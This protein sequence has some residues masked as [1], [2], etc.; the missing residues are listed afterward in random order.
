MNKNHQNSQHLESKKNNQ[1]ST[2]LSH[3]YHAGPNSNPDISRATK[4]SPPTVT[5]LIQEL[6]DDNL[7]MDMGMGTSI[8][9]RRPNLY[10]ILPDIRYVIG[11]DIDCRMVNIGLFNLATR[12]KADVITYFGN[13]KDR[14]QMF[15]ELFER[16]DE[17]LAA[18]HVDR[19]K[20]LG[21]GVSIPGL[22]NASTGETYE[23]I[24]ING[25]KLSSMF[26]ERFK[27]P[28]V[29]ENDSRVMAMGEQ[30]YGYA[31]G[32]ANVLCLNICDGIGM[33][34]ILNKKVYKG[35]SGLAGEL[36]HVKT[37]GNGKL[38]TCGK[39]GCLETVASGTALIEQAREGI[40]KGT[41]TLI[42]ELVNNNIDNI[43]VADI[44][45]ALQ[46]GD[47]FAI[48][49]IDQLGQHLGRALA[50]VVHLFNPEMI[51]I[52]GKVSVAKEYL[53]TP[54]ENAMNRYAISQM[55]NDTQIVSSELAKDAKLL[56]SVALV[57]EEAFSKKNKDI[58]FFK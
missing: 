4:L 6:I 41:P 18:A 26:K 2:I 3:L 16:I 45:E 36:G 53:I 51:I 43:H 7:V 50:S 19:D 39:S 10:G 11:V 42:K 37:E 56:G 14:Q 1:K 48:E 25:K 49:L 40:S 47:A 24:R 12:A 22:I 9:G 21:I 46:R 32:R 54:I 8:G 55:K 20:I 52:G 13:M 5:K 31:K 29:I 34:M 28:V 23:S 44:I 17:L 57:M 35:A 27:L 33:G 15:E 30:A 58:A 38:C